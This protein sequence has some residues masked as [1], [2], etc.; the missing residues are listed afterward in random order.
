MRNVRAIAVL[1][2]ATLVGCSSSITGADEFRM[3]TTEDSYAL[4]SRV[5]IVLENG[6]NDAVETSWCNLD[7]QTSEDGVSWVSVRANA[8]RCRGLGLYVPA[9][10]QVTTFMTLD[11]EDD[12]GVYRIAD[13]AVNVTTN[14]FIVGNLRD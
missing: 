11:E 3:F 9:N 14:S 2:V 7:L 10:S 1:I 4:G 8:D 13:T 6:T 5:E 12:V